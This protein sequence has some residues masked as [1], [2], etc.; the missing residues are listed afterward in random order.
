MAGTGNSYRKV[1]YLMHLGDTIGHNFGLGS[2][3]SPITLKRVIVVM[4]VGIGDA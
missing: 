1:Y 4:H 2:D 3:W